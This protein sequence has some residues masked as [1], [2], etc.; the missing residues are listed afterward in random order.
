MVARG[1]MGRGERG[2]RPVWTEIAALALLLGFGAVMAKGWPSCNSDLWIALGAIGSLSAAVVALGIALMN[3][4]EIR[5]SSQNKGKLAL[6]EAIPLIKAGHEEMGMFKILIHSQGGQNNAQLFDE[7]YAGFDS[8]RDGLSNNAIPMLEH[9][10]DEC[11]R[12]IAEAKGRLH[13]INLL[14]RRSETNKINTRF[15]ISKV[16]EQANQA[17]NLLGDALSKAEKLL[18]IKPSP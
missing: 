1:V 8:L 7:L 15:E 2:L 17:Y 3:N 9:L 12:L 13:A 18:G 5:A 16:S 10:P 14:L 4:R 6:T 11:A